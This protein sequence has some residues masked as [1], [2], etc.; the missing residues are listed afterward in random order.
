MGYTTLLI[1]KFIGSHI[2]M[3]SAS[4]V[5]L[6]IVISRV[7]QEHPV[8]ALRR[9]WIPKIFGEVSRSTEVF[10]LTFLLCSAVAY[11]ELGL[12]A[13]RQAY[14]V[15][16][17]LVNLFI[18]V[19]LPVFALGLLVKFW[20]Q[21]YGF[22]STLVVAK[23]QF[24]WRY[25]GV[26]TILLVLVLLWVYVTESGRATFF[27]V[28]GWI[29]GWS[30][31]QI[32]NY[33]SIVTFLTLF[34]STVV[35]SAGFTYAFIPGNAATRY[36]W[37]PRAT[38]IIFVTFILSHVFFWW[39]TIGD[40]WSNLWMR[41]S[42]NGS[43]VNLAL[44]SAAMSIILLSLMP[45]ARSWPKGVGLTFLVTTA[46]FWKY[47]VKAMIDQ[48]GVIAFITRTGTSLGSLAFTTLAYGW[49]WLRFIPGRVWSVVKS[50]AAL[51]FGRVI[52]PLLEY[53]DWQILLVIIVVFILGIFVYFRTM[54]YT[55]T[56]AFIITM[57][58]TVAVVVAQLL[59]IPLFLLR[60]IIFVITIFTQLFI[61][62]FNF[63]V[64]A[65]RNLGGAAGVGITLWLVV[66]LLPAP[67]P[68]AAFQFSS[69]VLESASGCNFLLPLAFAAGI[70]FISWRRSANS[71]P[72]SS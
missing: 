15:A 14:D 34:V 8:I 39:S 12:F 61:E 56:R 40:V 24:I 37:I 47:C 49:S 2:L 68:A 29:F 3:A 28:V 20:A 10:I 66:N 11:I 52:A 45:S 59:R 54:A 31:G 42:Q 26:S 7:P 5:L 30:S 70:G 46:F 57:L 65:G 62:V 67:E 35:T 9:T 27:W 71:V 63:I 36:T 23:S 72:M 50:L 48:T 58:L 1:R 53:L 44:G 32:F 51:I 69:P 6:M 13:Y 25:K 19:I 18:W 43:S 64:R 22:V 17:S 60:K 55:T 16:P 4:A 41:Y 33:I 21:V 38:Q